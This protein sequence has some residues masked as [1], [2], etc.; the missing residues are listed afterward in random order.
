MLPAASIDPFQGRHYMGVV[1]HSSCGVGVVRLRGSQTSESV[2]SVTVSAAERG[3]EELLHLRPRTDRRFLMP[4]S[5]RAYRNPEMR[6]KS[7]VAQPQRRLKGRSASA[8]PAAS[9]IHTTS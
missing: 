6:G 8:S 1:R 3:V 9:G 7:L 2:P 4:C 5:N